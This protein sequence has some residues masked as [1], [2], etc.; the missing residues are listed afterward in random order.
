MKEMFLNFLTL[1]DL[2]RR[3]VT[4]AT[5]GG[6]MTSRVQLNFIPQRH[7]YTRTLTHA[8]THAHAGTQ[9]HTHTHS[10]TH[11]CNSSYDIHNK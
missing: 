4:K 2:E 11:T 6:T 10:E 9:A 7:T 8:H 1:I 5:P 3:L